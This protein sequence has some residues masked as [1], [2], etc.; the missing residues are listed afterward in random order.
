[1]DSHAHTGGGSIHEPRSY[2]CR[3]L[4]FN[5]KVALVIGHALAVDGSYTA[6]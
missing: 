4:S 1:M 2:A 3:E 6:R 5:D